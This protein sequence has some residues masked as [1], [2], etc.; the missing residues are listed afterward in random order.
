MIYPHNFVNIK[1]DGNY[2]NDLKEGYGELKTKHGLYQGNFKND[3]FNGRGKYEY[4]D[5]RIQEGL[6]KDGVFVAEN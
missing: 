1:F 2:V 6:W 4:K 5:G 3:V